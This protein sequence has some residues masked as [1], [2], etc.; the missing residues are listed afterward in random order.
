MSSENGNTKCLLTLTH[1]VPLLTNIPILLQLVGLLK[2]AALKLHEFRA[3]QSL[4]FF[5]MRIPFS[6]ICIQIYFV[7][8]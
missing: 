2:N 6:I 7:F 5:E 1:R 3:Y 4:E 8:S